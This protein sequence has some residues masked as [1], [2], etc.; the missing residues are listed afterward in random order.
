MRVPDFV[1]V[2]TRPPDLEMMWWWSMMGR[3]TLSE[4][5]GETVGIRVTQRWVWASCEYLQRRGCSAWTLFWVGERVPGNL[6]SP[7]GSKCSSVGHM[8]NER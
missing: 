7:P 5:L 2:V 3:G 1:Q 6:L 8:A 4:H